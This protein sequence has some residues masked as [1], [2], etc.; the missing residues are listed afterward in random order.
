M[1]PFLDAIEQVIQ[2]TYSYVL[3]GEISAVTVLAMTAIWMFV[4][5]MQKNPMLAASADGKFDFEQTEPVF[6][7]LSDEKK[8]KEAALE[9]KPDEPKEEP[10]KVQPEPEAQSEV[11]TSSSSDTAELLA[12]LSKLE[13]ENERLKASLEEGDAIEADKILREKKTL[14]NKLKG[15]EEKLIE[16]EI[17]KE[18]IG[19]ISTLKTE[20]EQLKAKLGTKRAPS[21]KRTPPTKAIPETPEQA[22]EP[23]VEPIPMGDSD[24]SFESL[25]EDGEPGLQTFSAD[26][27]DVDMS[28]PVET[29]SEPTPKK[30]MNPQQLD[31][32]LGQI[33]DLAKGASKGN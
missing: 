19:M 7:T 16:F 12:K 11:Q 22:P 26:S 10:V 27:T 28:E 1:E 33:D 17:I 32:L 3:M 30:E 25:P 15:L 29:P 5:R 23:Q 8:E 9:K 24:V 14:E 2:G 31:D 21:V 18:E 4:R 6:T 20:N 13:I